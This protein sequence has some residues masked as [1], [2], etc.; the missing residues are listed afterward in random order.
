MVGRRH[1]GSSLVLV[2]SFGA[3]Y[4]APPNHSSHLTLQSTLGLGTRHHF[5]GPCASVSLSLSLPAPCSSMLDVFLLTGQL[6]QSLPFLPEGQKS[7]SQTNVTSETGLK[8]F[9]QRP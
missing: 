9:S 6:S 8:V 3:V 1:S 7:G 5:G 4:L 2:V